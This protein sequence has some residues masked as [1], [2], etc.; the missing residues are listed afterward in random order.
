VRWPPPM[1]LGPVEFGQPTDCR[2]GVV[3][4]IGLSMLAQVVKYAV[5]VD[6][7]C[8]EGGITVRPVVVQRPAGVVQIIAGVVVVES[9]SMTRDRGCVPIY[10]ALKRCVSERRTGGSVHS[11]THPASSP[12]PDRAVP[13]RASIRVCAVLT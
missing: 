1:L 12:D 11:A 8:A 9:P 10:G 7:I 6:D 5:V 13:A 2:R 3:I 4:I